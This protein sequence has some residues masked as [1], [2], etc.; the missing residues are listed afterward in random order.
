[1]YGGKEDNAPLVSVIMNCHNC[2]EYINEAIESVLTQTYG[3][4]E[5]IVW[6]NQS[7]DQTRDIVGS[8]ADPRVKYHYS[9]VF[10]ALGEARNLAIEKS[11]GSLIGFLDADDIWLTEKLEMQVPVFENDRIGICVCDS[12]FFNETGVTK[13]IYKNKKPPTGMVFRELLGSYF[14]SLETAVIRRSALDA[15]DEWFDP[16]FNMIEEY[17]LFV[18]IGYQWE[19]GYVDEVLAKWRMHENSWTWSYRQDFPLERRKMLK[20]LEEVIPDFNNQ[21]RD[22]VYL[23]NRTCDFEDARALWLD[24]NNK[25]ARARLSPYA[26]SGIKWYVVYVMTYLPYIY[27]KKLWKMLGG[28]A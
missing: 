5:L 9:N 18:R 7:T 16:R 17:D 27:Y 14:I 13:Q 4:W 10:T 2:A 22:Q 28:V 15:L 21:Y 20:K 3:N 26:F 12:Y 25:A 19:V 11:N 6:D 8:Y 24:R 23:V 1:M